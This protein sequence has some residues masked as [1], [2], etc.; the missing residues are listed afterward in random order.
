MHIKGIYPLLLLILSIASGTAQELYVPSNIYNP[1]WD[2][3]IVQQEDSLS[4]IAVDLGFSNVAPIKDKQD[5]AWISLFLI[6][7]S[8]DGLATADESNTLAKIEDQLALEMTQKQG[9]HYVGRITSDGHQDLFFY[10]GDPGHFEETV[11][12]LMVSFPDYLFKFGSK[13]DKDWNGY[14]KLLYPKPKTLQRIYSRRKFDDLQQSENWYTIP[15]LMQYQF[16]FKTEVDRNRFETLIAKD[17]F[18]LE[19]Q[20]TVEGLELPYC[21][22]IE[23]NEQIDLTH[24]GDTI[25][26]LIDQS[27]SCHGSF[28]GWEIKE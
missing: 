3:Y 12:Q 21:S 25:D 7:P 19:N 4:T 20:N 16:A 11:Y 13:E 6:N 2:F 27:E 1:D 5:I 23:R 26:W 28:Q 10:L 24:L 8:N 18:Q 17:G 22:K 14:F 15:K 9:A